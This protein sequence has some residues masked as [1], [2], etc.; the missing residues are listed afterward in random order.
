[1]PDVMRLL[2]KDF[3]DLANIV[4]N[5]YPSFKINT[6]EKRDD[7]KEKAIKTQNQDNGVDYYGLF[8]E[9]KMMG[10]MRLHDFNMNLFSNQV[11]A[12]GVGM[13]AVDLVHKK[14][15]VARELISFFLK[16]Y[17]DKGSAITCLYPF[18]PDF[19][20]KMGFGFGTK[21]NQYR[22]KPSCIPNKKSK[23]HIQYLVP[24][25]KNEVLECYNRYAS[26]THGM[27]LKRDM[28]IRG[29]LQNT[30]YKAIGFKENGRILGYMIFSFKAEN[31]DNFLINDLIIREM[32][33]ENKAVLSEFLTFLNTQEDQINRLIINTQDEDLHHLF[34]D[35]RNGTD[36]II[37][38]VFHVSNTQGVGL[39]YR[40]INTKLIFDILKNQDFGGQNLKLRLNIKDNLLAE[41]NECIIVHFVN[42]KP[43]IKEENDF[44]VEIEMDISDF[45]SMIMGVIGFKALYNYG[46]ANLSDDTYIDTINKLFLSE[47]KPVCM[48]AF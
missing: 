16:H 35:P 32:I 17:R 46:L 12:G 36:E 28:D 42:G 24:E 14:E 39:M 33:Y 4:S 47:D 2:E 26:K 44:D 34:S 31:E 45:S 38:S 25:D 13:V 9:N 15:K 30:E 40:I 11:L 20:K 19:Y 41:N 43:F 18:R 10:C 23:G 29:L 7:F 48:T 3:N 5:A 6:Q 37:P 1:M 21:M 27:I 22:I 8:R